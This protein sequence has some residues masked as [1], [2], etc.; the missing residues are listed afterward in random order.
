MGRHRT[1]GFP[2]AIGR[3]PP[4]LATSDRAPDERR[5]MEQDLM[6][7]VVFDAVATAAQLG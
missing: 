1:G 6:W 7:Q 3:T 5:V 2:G 4:A